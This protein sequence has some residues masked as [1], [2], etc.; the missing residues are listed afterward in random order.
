MPRKGTQNPVIP[1]KINKIPQ[2]TH[3]ICV[4]T[5]NDARS[6]TGPFRGIENSV[7]RLN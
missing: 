5:K 7:A 2:G 3:R 4:K 1:A 6:P